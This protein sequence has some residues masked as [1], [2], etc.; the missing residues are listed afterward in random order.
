[1]PTAR[2]S[3]FTASAAIAMLSFAGRCGDGSI[4]KKFRTGRMRCG[5]GR[6]EGSKPSST[7]PSQVTIPLCRCTLCSSWG[8]FVVFFSFLSAGERE[9]GQK[10][11]WKLLAMM[12]W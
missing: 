4:Q 6:D 11:T 3:F 7:K 8:G 5:E 12:L 9:E 2:S 10:P 1:M